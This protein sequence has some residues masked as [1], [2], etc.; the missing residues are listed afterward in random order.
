MPT[1]RELLE[2]ADALMRRNRARDSI[3]PMPSAPAP[4]AEPPIADIPVL[5][6]VVETHA[7]PVPAAA[8]VIPDVPVLTEA[9]EEIEAPALVA[10]IDQGEASLWLDDP[11]E[12]RSVLGD[13]PDSVAIVP[14]PGSP[15]ARHFA[16][17]SAV[18]AP[19][20]PLRTPAAEP[21]ARATADDIGALAPPHPADAEADVVTPMADEPVRTETFAETT[22]PSIDIGPVVDEGNEPTLEDDMPAFEVDAVAVEL[23]ATPIEVSVSPTVVDA[24]PTAIDVSPLPAAALPPGPVDEE[25]WRQLAEDVR[26]QVLQRIDIFTDT[27]LREQLGERLKPIVDRASADLV[28]TINQHVGEILRGYVA[29]AIEREIE[30]WRRDGDR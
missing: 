14:P 21:V 13:A 6:D 30:R 5:T 19:M 22:A 28:A 8:N 29:E 25:R 27:G 24:T 1:A 12:D 18:P 26:M 23:D 15:P 11:D 10:D 2:Q 16:S 20:A 17:D 7:P 4:V 3:Q 9:V